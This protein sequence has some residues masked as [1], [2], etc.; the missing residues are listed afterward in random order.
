LIKRKKGKKMAKEDQWLKWTALGL[1]A[2]LVMRVVTPIQGI[3]CGGLGLVQG[4]MMGVSFLAV[5]VLLTMSVFA[6]RRQL[7]E[8]S[9]R[10][11]VFFALGTG[12][13]LLVLGIL[14]AL[15]GC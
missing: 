15:V 4:A 12:A 6:I 13:A 3:A 11:G 9:A 7:E 14:S 5:V 1:F 8:D 10:V 2:I